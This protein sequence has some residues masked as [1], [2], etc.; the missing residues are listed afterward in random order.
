MKAVGLKPS[1]PG[2]VLPV[3]ANTATAYITI[4]KICEIKKAVPHI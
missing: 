2:E 3:L 1:P 4:T